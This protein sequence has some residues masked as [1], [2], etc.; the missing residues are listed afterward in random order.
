MKLTIRTEL[1]YTF[2]EATQIIASIEAARSADQDI[3]EEDLVFEPAAELVQSQDLSG[4][5]RLRAC[6]SGQTS[7]V[8]TASVENRLRQL[9]PQA[10]RQHPWAE[11]PEHTLPFLLPSRFCPSDTFMRFAQRQFGNAGD[12]V[13]RVMA[14]LAWITDNVDYIHGVSTAETTAGRT[15]VDRAGVCRDFTHLGITLCRALSIPA[16]AVAAYALGLEPPDFH[17]VFEVY[18][19][20]Q[21]W[22]VDPTR[23]APIEGIVRIGSGRDAADIAFLTTDKPCQLV[24]QSVEI[25][26]AK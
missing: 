26:Q 19:E 16:R 3:I 25:E 20:G 8:Y 6:L 4:D 23:L 10:G 14:V 18:L 11:L 15:F 9:L 13:A 1:V 22:L 12:G 24:R 7:I 17:A 2:A 21:W 5:R